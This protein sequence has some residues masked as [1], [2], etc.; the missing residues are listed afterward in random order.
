MRSLFALA[1]ALLSACSP[2]DTQVGPEGPQGPSGVQGEMGVPGVPGRDG[3]L[4]S[5]SPTLAAYVVGGVA[6]GAQ[7]VYADYTGS[8]SAIIGNRK[9]I[10]VPPGLKIS[11]I[12]LN[13]RDKAPGN[14]VATL[15][16]Q[17]G[18]S[19]QAVT[20]PLQLP[21]KAQ[22]TGAEQSVIVAPGS[23]LSKPWVSLILTL[24]GPDSYTGNVEAFVWASP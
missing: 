5:T 11:H 14:D 9:M 17:E 23:T 8:W 21:A 18:A 10:F 6:D 20:Q 22:L 4:G 12:A 2:L 24:T 3:V 13:L 7:P 15:E 1:L 19:F 16:V